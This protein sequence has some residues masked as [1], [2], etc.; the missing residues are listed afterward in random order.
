MTESSSPSKQS[1]EGELVGTSLLGASTPHLT[2]AGTISFLLGSALSFLLKV[3]AVGQKM[4]PKDV[5]MRGAWVAQSVDFGSGHDLTVCGVGLC[6]DSSEPGA[7]FGFCVPLSLLMLM[8]CLS[9][10]DE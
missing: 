7:C 10:K 3:S 6:A 5:H 8:L 9:L 1:F 4:A 2:V